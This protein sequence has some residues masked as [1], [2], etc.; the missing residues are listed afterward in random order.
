MS[1]RMKAIYRYGRM[2]ALPAFLWAMPLPAQPAA[3]HVGHYYLQGVMETGSELLL[4][5]DGRFQWY[6]SVGALDLF[7]AGTW[8]ESNNGIILTAQKA[9]DMPD[10]PFAQLT[11]TARDDALIPPDGRGA[12]VRPKPSDD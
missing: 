10:P 7:A 3:T 1:R 5:A 12:Y 8:A 4:E 9:K 11:L 2:L 6:L